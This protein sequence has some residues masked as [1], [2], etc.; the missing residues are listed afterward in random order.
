[1]TV[2]VALG[3]DRILTTDARW[4]KLTVDVEVLSG[5]R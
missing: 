3:A 2:A 5:A 4:P 1:L